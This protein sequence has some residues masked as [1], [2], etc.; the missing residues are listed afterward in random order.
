MDAAVS[1]GQVVRCELESK[2]TWF[3]CR[4]DEVRNDGALLCTI[5][6]TQSWPDLMLD[7]FVPGRQY[8]LQKDQVLS[9]VR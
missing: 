2:G 9:V 3:Y 7:G 5:V 4:V 8:A 1:A 6:D